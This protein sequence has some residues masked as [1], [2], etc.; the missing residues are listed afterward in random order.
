MRLKTETLVE[1]NGS[2]VVRKD[3]QDHKRELLR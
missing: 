2:A 1:A 3:I